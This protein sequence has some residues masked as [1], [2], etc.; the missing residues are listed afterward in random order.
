ML[1]GEIAGSILA[2]KGLSSVGGMGSAAL[3]RALP[4]NTAGMSPLVRQSM[5]AARSALDPKNAGLFGRNLATDATYGAAY[6]GV[7]EG[8]P[9]RGAA[10]AGG[11]SA[12]GQGLGAAAGRTISGIT[13]PVSRAR[14]LNDAG[15]TLSLGQILRDREGWGGKAI[16]G[17]EDRLAGLPF[18]GN[19]I[20]GVRTRGV[21]DYNIVDMSNSLAPIGGKVSEAG[22]GGYAQADQAVGDAYGQALGPMRLQ[23]DP[24]M[25]AALDKYPQ[26]SPMV[27]DYIDN[28]IMTGEGFQAA[29]Q[30]LSSERSK[31]A[32]APGGYPQSKQVQGLT[33]ELLAMGDR[34]APDLMNQYRAADEAFANLAPR[35]AAVAGAVNNSGIYTP[36]Q[37][38]IKL[39]ATDRSAGKRQTALG[40]RPGQDLQ[41][42]AQAQLPSLVPDSEI[43]RAH[44]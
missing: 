39:R 28:G 19:M 2:T 17:I 7:T 9:L 15:I 42:D 31:L 41:S 33:D 36:A 29:K 6:G 11:G 12:L 32:Q 21:E 24:A 5:I 16:S 35:R 26:Y 8:D 40:A 4:A 38:G 18:I 30:L 44:V 22:Q 34:Q 27:N 37:L 14:N 20:G 10:Y 23:P 43:G 25:N 13:S 3:R 1:G